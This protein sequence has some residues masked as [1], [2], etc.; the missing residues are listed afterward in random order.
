MPIFDSDYM[1]RDGTSLLNNTETGDAVDLGSAPLEGLHIGVFLPLDATDVT[2]YMEESDTGSSGWSTI[3]GWP[4]TLTVGVRTYEYTL[5][6]T[7]RYVRHR[8]SACTGSWGYAQIGPI[9]GLKDR[10]P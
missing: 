3:D 7:K 8:V 9:F 4:K 6:H 2:I 1:F 10:T 5:R